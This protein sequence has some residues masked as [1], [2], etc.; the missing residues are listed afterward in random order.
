MVSRVIKDLYRKRLRD[1]IELLKVPLEQPYIQVVANFL[2]LIFGNSKESDLYWQ[3]TVKLEMM[4]KYGTVGFSK[5]ELSDETIFKKLILKEKIASSPDF[6][7]SYLLF[8]HLKE[9]TGFKLEKFIQKQI[10]EASF[11]IQSLTETEKSGY[12]YPAGTF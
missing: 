1:K 4:S 5:A 11:L 6:T 7:A 10:N 2:N 3:T 9:L 8:L 12:L